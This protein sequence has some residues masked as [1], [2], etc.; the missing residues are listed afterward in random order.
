MTS[1]RILYAISQ[2]SILIGH[3]G[4]ASPGNQFLAH[5]RQ[6]GNQEQPSGIHQRKADQSDNLLAMKWLAS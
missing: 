3:L 5:W 6:E 2:S 1:T 4:S